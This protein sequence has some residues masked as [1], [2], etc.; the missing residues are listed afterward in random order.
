MYEGF[1]NALIE[2]MAHGVAC[3]SYDCQTGPSEI[4]KSGESGVLVELN[5]RD[6]FVKNLN[7]LMENESLRVRYSKNAMKL[8]DELSLEKISNEYLNFITAS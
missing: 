4:I 3:I 6:S 2:A 7:L 5:N 1:P 8:N